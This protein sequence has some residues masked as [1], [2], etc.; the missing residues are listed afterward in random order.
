LKIVFMGTPAFAVPSLRRIA[1]EPKF[2]VVGVVTQPDRPKG[3]G[4]KISSPPVKKLAEELGL[5]VFQPDSVNSKEALEIISNWKPDVIVVVAFGQ[6][7]GSNVLSLPP[8]GCINLH[9]S[10]LPKYRGAAPIQWAIINGES[11]TGVTTMFMDEKLDAG[12]IILQEEVVIGPD[13]TAGEL[14]GKLAKVGSG[15]LV[16]SLY[17]L[18]EGKVT[19]KKQ[20]DRLASY[21]PV[22]TRKDEKINWEKS[23]VEIVNRIRGMNPWP[24]AYTML[25]GSILKIWRAKV[26]KHDFKAGIPGKVVKVSKEGFIVQAGRGQ[27]LVTEVQPQNKAKMLAGDFIRG[28]KIQEGCI[29]EAASS[30]SKNSGDR[31]EH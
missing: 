11:K 15:L 8:L 30:D 10:L 14:H 9:A 27:V 19:G 4:R 28:R 2:K 29:F 16:K 20:D 7:L 3:R 1:G 22:L 13:E 12:D 21:A 6:I 26:Y 24:G 25:N 31:N 23:A 5:E 17:M 18:A